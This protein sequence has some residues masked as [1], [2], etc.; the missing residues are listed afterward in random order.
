MRQPPFFKYRYSGII[1]LVK[2]TA[3]VK[4]LTSQE[5]H[6]ALKHTLEVSNAACNYI[7]E[8]AW[9]SHTFGQYKLHK[10]LYHDVRAKF[11]LT[12]QIVVRCIAKVADAYKLD[13]RTQRVFKPL[14]SIAFDD[15]ILHWYVDQVS[16]ST[17]Q[18]RMKIPFA[19]GQRQREQLK[20]Q[21]G[22]SDLVLQ[23]N[24]FY[25]LA[26]CN[27]EEP[28]PSDVKGVLGVD[29]GIVNIAVDS[30]REVFS[31]S[32]INGLRHRHRRLRSKLQVKG[33]KSAK[34]LLKKRSQK[35]TRFARDVNH[36]ISKRLVAKAQGTG[37]A[38]AIEDL[39]G[40]RSRFTVRKS[41]R[42]TFSSWAFDQL[43]QFISYKAKLAGVPLVL[44]DRSH[45]SDTCPKC[46]TVSRSNRRSQSIFSC[47]QCGFAGLADYIAALNIQGR[48][49]VNWPIVPR[50]PGGGVAGASCLL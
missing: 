50:L 17:C 27:I 9:N 11:K 30:D 31:G 37:R 46:G 34:R 10:L 28:E 47:I 43:R 8:Q 38:I 48:A 18:G 12:A 23:D 5:Q 42:A 1:N 24:T 33:T 20:L 41:Q 35:E 15:R 13:K 3:Q 36:C 2:I 4:L 14:G 22:E 7:S 16:I 6:Q 39:A 49:I 32:Q 44:V 29:F 25:L 21:Q 26:T 19:C 40:I 45:T